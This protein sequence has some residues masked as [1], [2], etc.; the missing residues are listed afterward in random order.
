[1]QHLDRCFRKLTID[2][3]D[4][5][6]YTL[7]QEQTGEVETPYSIDGPLPAWDEGLQGW[8]LNGIHLTVPLPPGAVLY[9]AF[10]TIPVFK[11][12][13]RGPVGLPLSQLSYG[14]QFL[15]PDTVQQS[16]IPNPQNP[17]PGQTNVLNDYWIYPYFIKIGNVFGCCYQPIV[18]GMPDSDVRA[19]LWT[20]GSNGP[21]R[22]IYDDYLT[23]LT[24]NDGNYYYPDALYAYPKVRTWTIYGHHA[25]RIFGARFDNSN[26]QFVKV[27]RCICGSAKLCVGSVPGGDINV[28][29]QAGRLLDFWLLTP[30]VLRSCKLNVWYSFKDNSQE[31]IYGETY[32]LEHFWKS[33]CGFR[34]VETAAQT[35]DCGSIAKVT[36]PEP[37]N[38]QRKVFLYFSGPQGG[39]LVEPGD[40]NPTRYYVISTLLSDPLPKGTWKV[41]FNTDRRSV[42]GLCQLQINGSFLKDI[43][44]VIDININ[45]PA[46]ITDGGVKSATAK[47]E[48]A[49]F[50][51]VL[52]PDTGETVLFSEHDTI[53]SPEIHT[54]TDGNDIRWSWTGP[55]DK[56]HYFTTYEPDYETAL[57][58]YRITITGINNWCLGHI[59][60]TNQ[61][62]YHRSSNIY[63]LTDIS[64]V[65]DE[66][67]NR[68][69]IAALYAAWDTN[70]QQIPH[71]L[72]INARIFWYRQNNKVVFIDTY[73]EAI[74]SRVKPVI[75]SH[76]TTFFGNSYIG[77]RSIGNYEAYHTSGD[78]NKVDFYTAYGTNPSYELTLTVYGKVQQFQ[79]ADFVLTIFL[80]GIN[81]GTV[82]VSLDEL[83]TNGAIHWK[84]GPNDIGFMRTDSV[85]DQDE[86]GTVY[87]TL[88][89]P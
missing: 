23:Q 47:I 53:E 49:P 73:G 15:F 72:L 77:Y 86:P 27:P 70:V 67:V 87:V 79:G 4:I 28:C 59:V 34:L 76:G 7:H 17:W 36:V 10:V 69:L 40:P 44:D 3:T 89:L 66:R 56:L 16:L 80:W 48:E 43:N 26:A 64:S 30:V 88:A 55:I 14:W 41:A 78:P 25:L 39:Y 51:P 52:I 19:A 81:Q 8:W 65:I 33:E 9:E 12:D 1:M 61:I 31:P 84:R 2:L 22:F 68:S 46:Y 5:R 62:S 42:I 45:E 38:P 50:F 37:N 20:D 58:S 83:L 57:K 13:L 29:T 35:L 63:F 60:A 21:K 75:F 71:R 32:W 54:C 85:P 74:L 6:G 82:S 24:S 18:N 11:Y